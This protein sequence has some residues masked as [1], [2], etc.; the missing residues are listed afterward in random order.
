MFAYYTRLA[1]HSFGR[2]PGLTALMVLAIALGI[3]VS[4]MTL[5]VYHGMSG[6]P[7][8]WRSDRLYTVT[9]DNWDPQNPYRADAA[10]A[11]AGADLPRRAP[12][13]RLRHP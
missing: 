12:P 7:I 3:A 4:V 13:V 5:T 2:N 10:P 11:T 1:L 6:N 8:W 9:M